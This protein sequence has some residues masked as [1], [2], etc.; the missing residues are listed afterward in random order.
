MQEHN[1]Q[2]QSDLVIISFVVSHTPVQSTLKLVPLL[3]KQRLLASL[4]RGVFQ[5]VVMNLDFPSAISA[6]VDE[7]VRALGHRHGQCSRP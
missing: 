6:Q 4:N 5:P 2:P 3:Q 7:L 1:K